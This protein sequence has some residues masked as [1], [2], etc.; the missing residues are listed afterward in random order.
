MA[1]RNWLPK[2]SPSDAPRTMPAISTKVTDAGKIRSEAK[3]RA[4]WASRSSGTDDHADV[5][6]DGGEG[7]VRRE[8]VV[9]GEGIEQRGLAHVGKSDDTY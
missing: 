9:V 1:A 7:V 3:T 4:N 6:F 8:D 2:P 5:G